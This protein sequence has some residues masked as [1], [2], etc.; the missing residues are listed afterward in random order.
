MPNRAKRIVDR[1]RLSFSN[2]DDLRRYYEAK[3]HEGGYEQGGYVIHGV[4]VS[5]MYHA[6]RLETAVRFL[7]PA[8]SDV[9]LEAG[10]GNG[11]LAGQLAPRCREIHAVDLAANALD[12]KFARVANLH[13]RPMNVEALDYPDGKFDGITSVETLE[14]VLT[15][16]K[17]IV[18]LARVLRP[19]GRLVITYPTINRTLV[20]RWRL[21]RNVPISEHLNE[22][23]FRDLVAAM[24]SA[25]LL[26]DRVEGLAF[27]PGVLL[28]LKYISRFFASGIT[29]A[30]LAIRRFPANSMFVAMR[31]RKP[32]SSGG[33]R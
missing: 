17:A 3:Y 5:A 13:F 26:V 18:E 22:W 27:D 21:G 33:N 19:G 6:S 7:E 2:N 14:H 16:Q 9:L 24:E 8:P 11:A 15:P 23:S 25:G 29:R 30:S 12:P 32:P 4:N 20:K 31:M 1:E 28:A 10:C